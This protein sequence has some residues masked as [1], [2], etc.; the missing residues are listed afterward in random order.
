MS[1]PRKPI[2]MQKAHNTIIEK[3]NKKQEEQYVITG[4]NQLKTPPKWLINDIAKKEWRRIVKELNKIE[5]IG[6]LDYANLAGYCNAYANYIKVTENF[7]GQ[8]YCI[9]RETRTGKIVVKNPMIDVQATYA[10]EMRRFASLCG[11]TIDSRLKAAVTKKNK[12]DKELEE[13]FGAI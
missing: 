9:E 8:E 7:S 6:N 12:K 5:I 4:N 11:L 10:A 1:K 13:K 2:D 3:R